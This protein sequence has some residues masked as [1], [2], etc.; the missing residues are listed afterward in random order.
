MISWGL[1]QKIKSC[2]DVKKEVLAVNVS[3]FSVF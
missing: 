2:F 1:V 3:V